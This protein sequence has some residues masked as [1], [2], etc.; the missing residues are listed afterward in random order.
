MH[1]KRLQKN[2]FVENVWPTKSVLCIY[3]STHCVERVVVI[4]TFS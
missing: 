4:D 1:A 3:V 2:E